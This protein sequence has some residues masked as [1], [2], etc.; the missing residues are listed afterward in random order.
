MTPHVLIVSSRPAVRSRACEVLADAACS[1]QTADDVDRAIRLLSSSRLPDAVVLDMH[2]VGAALLAPRVKAETQAA[3][4][5]FV[6]VPRTLDAAAP[7]SVYRG[8]VGALFAE[9]VLEA[10]RARSAVAS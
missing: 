1:V 2:T 10:C 4:V 9:V 8:L 3:G 6:P 5:P 7:G